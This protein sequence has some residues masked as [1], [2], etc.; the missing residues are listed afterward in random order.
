[1]TLATT[2]KEARKQQAV[3]EI[4]RTALELFSRDGFDATSVEQIAEAAGCSPRTFYRY[5][6]TKEEV[7]FHDLPTMNARLSEILDRHL[8]EGLAPWDAVA[9]SFIELGTRFD[10]GDERMATQRMRLWL[11]EPTLLGRYIQYVTHAEQIVSDCLHRHR[12]TT[13]ENDEVVELMAVAA[14]GAYRVTALTHMRR[15]E[16]LNIGEHL[17]VALAT[18]GKSF[19]DVGATPA[20][21]KRRRTRSGAPKKAA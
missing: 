12:G 18:F 7:M 1:M 15:S 17:R 20:A 2:L 11:V 13:P 16:T 14:T 4:A 19:A 21:P 6:G 9:E 5:F 8:D 3:H 10:D